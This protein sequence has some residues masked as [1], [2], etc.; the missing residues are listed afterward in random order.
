MRRRRDGQHVLILYT[1]GGVPFDNTVGRSLIAHLYNT[2][3]ERHG[4]RPQVVYACKQDSKGMWIQDLE[5]GVMAAV[6][7]YSPGRMS[8]T[9]RQKIRK[10]VIAD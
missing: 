6:R 2:S 1:D 5:R 8:K 10:R 3:A 9:L 4:G 7:T